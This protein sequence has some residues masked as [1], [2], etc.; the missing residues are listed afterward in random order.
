MRLLKCV[1]FS[2]NY[3]VLWT[4]GVTMVITFKTHCKAVIEC[5]NARSKRAFK[6]CCHTRFQH[7]FTAWCCDFEEITYVD[8][9]Q[10]NY[11]EN[12]NACSKRTLKTRVATRL[13]MT[14]MWCRQ[15]IYVSQ[16]L[17]NSIIVPFESELNFPSLFNFKNKSRMLTVHEKNVIEKK[18]LF[19]LLFFF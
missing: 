5:T 10:R 16:I 14:I 6:G 9:N 13:Y 7:T 12:P 18:L 15:V 2:C 17:V 19:S 1:V 3:I 8:S 4:L 11:C